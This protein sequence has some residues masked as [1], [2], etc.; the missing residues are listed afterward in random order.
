MRGAQQA[1]QLLRETGAEEVIPE[2]D[3]LREDMQQE[4]RAM[5]AELRGEESEGERYLSNS[6][7]RVEVE[8]D[9]DVIRGGG[10][11]GDGGVDINASHCHSQP[12][13]PKGFQASDAGSS[14]SSSSSSSPTPAPDMWRLLRKK[15]TSRALLLGC[16]L[17]AAQQ[18][19][20]INTVMYYGATIFTLAGASRST[21]YV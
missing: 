10:F 18:F 2:L 7:T 11:K 16:A 21:R 4:Q 5:L 8:V 6:N 20:G 1:L 3:A 13:M 14:S 12:V 9:V 19:G 17:Q 15:S